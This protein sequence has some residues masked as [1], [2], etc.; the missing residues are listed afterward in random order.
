MVKEFSVRFANT[1]D[2]QNVFDLSNDDLVRKNSI[3][4]NKIEWADHVNWF[5]KRIKN[6]DEPFYIAET[7][8]GK[9]I[10]QI[11]FDKEYDYFVIS[12]SINKLFRGK[13]YGADLIKEAT[14]KLNKYPVVAYVKPDNIPSQKAFVK[15]GYIYQESDIIR[16]EPFERYIYKVN[17]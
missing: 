12:V 7:S 2:I 11:R 15:A 6:T 17:S 4:K 13:G 16:N 3:N 14:K 8:E 9:F 10:A 5:N 1:D